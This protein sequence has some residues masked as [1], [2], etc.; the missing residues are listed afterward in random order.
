[1]T[2]DICDVIKSID[3][4][5]KKVALCS[6]TLTEG[7]GVTQVIRQQSNSLVEAGYDVTVFSLNIDTDFNSKVETVSY[8]WDQTTYSGRLFRLLFFLFPAFLKSIHSLSEFD[9]VV[10][11]RYPFTL[12]GYIASKISD[13]DYVFWSHPSQEPP[14]DISVVSRIWLHTL[15]Y[16]ETSHFSIK[17][18]DV[19]CTVSEQSKEY[20]KK[21]VHQD[22]TVIHNKA[23]MDRFKNPASREEVCSQLDLDKNVTVAIYVGRI[24]EKKN[25]NTLIDVFE[26]NVSDED[27]QLLL[28]GKKTMPKYTSR[29]E[30]QS[31]SRVKFTGFVSD[32]VL[33]QLYSMSDVFVTCSMEEGWGLPISEADQFG[34]PIIAFETH[35]AAQHISDA[36]TVPQGDNEKFGQHLSNVLDGSD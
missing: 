22:I 26:S 4:N 31:S 6:F 23:N 9:V 21:Y 19:I 24:T 18:A 2:I 7:D 32:E 36:I 33:A 1:M 34:L 27:T 3:K 28:V 29:L 11:H 35:P 17:G 13:V 12:S 30:R 16:L 20:I 25:I 8:S 15:K 14:K 10:T 5:N